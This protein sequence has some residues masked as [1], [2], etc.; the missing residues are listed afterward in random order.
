MNLTRRDWAVVALFCALTIIVV[1]LALVAPL[2]WAIAMLAILICASVLLARAQLA[3]RR[4]ADQRLRRESR[5]TR[6]ATKRTLQVA[7]RSLKQLDRTR[8]A[9]SSAGEAIRVATTSESARTGAM[10][11][12]LR[13]VRVSQQLLSLSMTSLRESIEEVSAWVRDA[14][15]KKDM[16][17]LTRMLSDIER[18]R[19]DASNESLRELK[20]A[21]EGERPAMVR[22]ITDSLHPSV[23]SLVASVRSNAVCPT[24]IVGAAAHVLF[25][26]SGGAS[27]IVSVPGPPS[28]SA[29]PATRISTG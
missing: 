27:P 7:T 16:D 20:L 14:S 9:A 1:L 5:A 10:R 4:N 3:S 2:R 12:E 22:G 28:H 11:A 26:G 24:P 15:T 29:A 13:G 6:E 25:A 18:H 17:E 19:Q 8:L 23:S 21:L